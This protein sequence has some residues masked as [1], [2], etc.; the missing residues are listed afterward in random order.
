MRTEVIY[1]PG[2]H[3]RRKSSIIVPSAIACGHFH[4]AWVGECR[5]WT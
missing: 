5:G 2:R 4:P 1:A 3:L